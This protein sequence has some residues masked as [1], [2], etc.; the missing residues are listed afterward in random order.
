MHCRLVL[1]TVFALM[2]VHP[3]L[4]AEPIR[5]AIYADEGAMEPYISKA[6][7]AA[8]AA[9]MIVSRV[10]AADI[11]AGVLEKQD[12]IVF[13]GGTGNGL[14]RSLGEEASPIVRAFA[15]DGGGVIGVCA[16]G[17]LLAEGYN[18]GTNRLELINAR[19]WDLDNWER[20][21]GTVQI[22]RT[23][24]PD[25][26]SIRIRFENAPV[27][28]PGT[29]G[30]NLPPYVSLARFVSDVVAQ[31]EGRESMAGHDAI[32]AAPFGEGRVV[33][34]GPHPE[35][36]PGLEPLFQSALIWAAGE[37][38]STPSWDSV[39]GRVAASP[40]DTAK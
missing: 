28:E 23:D 35:L 26:E 15:A 1:L 7:E 21:E 16:G 11:V 30:L 13:P 38:E 20:G 34:F 25:N 36:T 29:K 5:V 19:L 24:E 40:E 32:I 17:Y 27:F 9:G 37:G 6:A 33:L 18:E 2:T 14:A 4:R 8:E 22:Q 31:P 39:L 12:V 3:L 10:K